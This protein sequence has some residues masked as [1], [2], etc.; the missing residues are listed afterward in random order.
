MS[1]F[2]NCILGNATHG[3]PEANPENKA[4][5]VSSIEKK[6]ELGGA[7]LNQSTLEEHKSLGG[8]HSSLAEGPHFPLARLASNKKFSLPL[9]GV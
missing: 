7:V 5:E 8:D 4:E 9:A 2:S 3:G 6:G 1:L